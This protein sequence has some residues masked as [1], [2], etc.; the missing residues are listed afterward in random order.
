MV[1]EGKNLHCMYVCACVSVYVCVSVCVSVCK[2]ASIFVCAGEHGSARV[3]G[4]H[5]CIS[6][7]VFEYTRLCK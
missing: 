4:V 7:H 3:W 5:V 2:C 6:M 1:K